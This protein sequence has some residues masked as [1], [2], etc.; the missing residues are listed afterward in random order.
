MHYTYYK[1]NTKLGSILCCEC[2]YYKKVDG[3]DVVK[4]GELCAIHN[5]TIDPALVLP[6]ELDCGAT[7]Y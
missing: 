7:S 1:D 3:V 6:D 2:C 4:T 5:Q